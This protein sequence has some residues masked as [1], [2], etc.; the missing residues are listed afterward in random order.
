M[1]SAPSGGSGSR[2]SGHPPGYPGRRRHH[3]GQAR[4]LVPR[5]H[6]RRQRYWK[7]HAG[8]GVPSQRR[9]R[10]DS[11]RSQGRRVRSQDDGVGEHGRDLAS[12]RYDRRIIFHSSIF[13][14]AVELRVLNFS[15]LFFYTR[16]FQK[17]GIARKGG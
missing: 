6:Q 9:I 3:H 14:L 12:W 4:E 13:R 16:G 2:P 8:R 5:H 15:Q 1:L 7:E 10:H 17:T 11:R